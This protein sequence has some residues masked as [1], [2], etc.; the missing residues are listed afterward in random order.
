[1]ILS[2]NGPNDNNFI[3]LFEIIKDRI[4]NLF[5]EYKVLEYKFDSIQMICRELPDK[6]S[7]QVNTTIK[8]F[9]NIFNRYQY[10]NIIRDFI[11]YGN[12]FYTIGLSLK[13]IKQ[14]EHIT[15]V[16]L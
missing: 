4:K 2:F 15:E 7:K 3:L 1:M 9:K 6:K 14:A 8:E 10:D 11:L 16:P 12:D 5:E 13:V